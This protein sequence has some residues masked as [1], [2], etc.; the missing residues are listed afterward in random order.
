MLAELDSGT[1]DSLI[2]TSGEKY[3]SKV[4]KIA[5][6]IAFVA[7]VMECS[8]MSGGGYA[9]VDLPFKSHGMH[10]GSVLDVSA[11][12]ERGLVHQHLADQ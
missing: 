4:G 7:M 6:F 3:Q 5:D 10:C 9:L 1:G 12:R 8:V 2:V 11:A